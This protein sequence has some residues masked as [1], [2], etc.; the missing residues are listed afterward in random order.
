MIRIKKMQASCGKLFRKL[1]IIYSVNGT[2]WLT[3]VHSS[4]VGNLQFIKN[5]SHKPTTKSPQKLKTN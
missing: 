4:Y 1:V 3:V 5:N 2:H